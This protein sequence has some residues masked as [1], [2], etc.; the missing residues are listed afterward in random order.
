MA[1]RSAALKQTIR[2]L[3]F[4]GLSPIGFKRLGGRMAP[5]YLDTNIGMDATVT[6]FSLSLMSIAA[7]AALII[8]GSSAPAFAAEDAGIQARQVVGAPGPL[9]G[10]TLFRATVFGQGD[11]AI[12]LG[13]LAPEIGQTPAVMSLADEVVAEI[14]RADPVYFDRFAAMAQSGSVF[15]VDAAFAETSS[16]FDSAITSLGYADAKPGDMVSPQWAAVA[17]VL[18]AVG[19]VVYA[20]AAVLQVNMVATTNLWWPTATTSDAATLSQERWVASMTTAL[21]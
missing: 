20:G 4:A 18:F 9:D 19:A 10:E 1:G 11:P 12:K 5:Q 3:C 13:E 14:Q 16:Q 6:K 7:S 17:I 15:E 2:M 21:D 8:A